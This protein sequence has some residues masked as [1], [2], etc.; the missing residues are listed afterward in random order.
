MLEI[1]IL[2][3]L[4]ESPMHGYELR[5]RLSSLLGS[6]RAFSYGS[7]YPTLRRLSEAGWIEERIDEDLISRAGRSRRAKRVYRLTAD[8]KEHFQQLL[9]QVG[10]EAFGDEGFG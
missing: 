10:P 5:K 3:L 4:N 6:F 8:G 9:E 1:A 7:L 2:G